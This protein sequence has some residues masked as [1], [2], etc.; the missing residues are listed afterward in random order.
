M[1][2]FI[3]LIAAV[4]I[5]FIASCNETKT[6]DV[7]KTEDP[8]NAPT[9]DSTAASYK[10]DTAASIVTWVGKKVT[11]K[12]N[13]TFQLS[14]GSLEVKNANIVAGGFTININSMKSLDGSPEDNG[15]LT[16]HLLS[17]DFFDAAKY[18]TAKFV[19]TSVAA[20]TAPTDTTK[21]TMLQGATHN[22]TGNLTLKEQT[23]SVTFPAIVTI[24]GDMVSANTLFVFDRTNWGLSYGADKSLKDKMI[25]PE[26]ELGIN[27]LSKK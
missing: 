18:P 14:E 27:L 9:T 20:Y 26:V 8:K 25:Y 1:K 12:H 16:G 6:A 13:G 24:N 2:K 7:A 19:V 3:Y 17:P 23:K 4:A 22:I 15:K 5:V 21:K 11:G 10:V